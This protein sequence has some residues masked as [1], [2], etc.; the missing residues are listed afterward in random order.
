MNLKIEEQPW[1][2]ENACSLP[3]PYVCKVVAGDRQV[4]VGIFCNERVAKHL[5]RT[6]NAS[7]A[8]AFSGWVTRSGLTVAAIAQQLNVTRTAVYGWL[9]G[10]HRPSANNLA[11][12]ETLSGG[13]VGPGTFKDI[14]EEGDDEA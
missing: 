14:V 4:L 11:M 13:E 10:E 7:M 12:L 2:V 6:H 8:H 3:A 9:S 5:V 1:S